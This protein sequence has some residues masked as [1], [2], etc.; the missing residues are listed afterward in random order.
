MEN[1]QQDILNEIMQE[2][3]IEKKTAETFSPSYFP[4]KTESLKL[5]EEEFL[6]KQRLL[7]IQM[8]RGDHA[9]QEKQLQKEIARRRYAWQKMQYEKQLNANGVNLFWESNRDFAFPKKVNPGPI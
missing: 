9:L 3:L 8:Q 2:K 5:Q 1:N 6:L 4:E 7:Q